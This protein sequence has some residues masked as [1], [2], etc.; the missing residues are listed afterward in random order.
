MRGVD[1]AGQ[2]ALLADPH[3]AQ[4][5]ADQAQQLLSDPA[6]RKTMVDAGIERARIFNWRATAASTL[7]LYEEVCR[8]EITQPKCAEV[9]PIA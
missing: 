6:L 3:D 8:P 4:S 5:F 9:A 2:A 1:V 7:A